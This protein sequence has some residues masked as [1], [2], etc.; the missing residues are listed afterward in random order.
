VFS[1][2]GISGVWRLKPTLTDGLTNSVALTSDTLE[3]TSAGL[4]VIDDTLRGAVG[5]MQSLQ[6]ALVT[7]ADALESTEPMISAVIDLVDEDLPETIRAT[8][9]SLDSAQQSAE[10]IDS[11]LEALSNLP[12][13]DYEPEKPLHESLDE[14]STRLGEFP[15]SFENISGS[16]DAS[17]DQLQ[18]LKADLAMMKDAVGQIESS[19]DNSEHVLAQYQKSVDT[20]LEKLAILEERIPVVVD[21]AVWIVTLFLIWLAFAQIGIFIQGVSLMKQEANNN[22]VTEVQVE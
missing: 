19:L 8:Q 16:L 4:A 21:G 20:A 5:S 15:D 7:T 22:A 12:F 2:L 9:T 13:V 10:I 6:S 1:L 17:R 11:V 14:I 18:I 3:I